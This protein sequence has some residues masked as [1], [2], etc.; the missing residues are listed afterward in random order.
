[1]LQEKINLKKWTNKDSH[2]FLQSTMGKKLINR[3]MKDGR[4]D[5]AE[6]I[7]CDVL[8]LLSETLA[9]NPIRV[10]KVA[11]KNVEPL[12]EVKTIRLRGAHYSVPVP[13]SKKRRSSLSM[14]W[15]IET[16]RKKKKGPIKKMLAEEIL[17]A[18]K[19]QGESLKKKI[20]VHKLASANRAY[21]H[22]RWF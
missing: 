12:V 17:L 18:Y 8:L 4:K 21:A 13:L 3:I 1:M 9:Q 10:L 20:S 5:K 19:Q 6:K 7:L 11:I 22:F 14:K 16:S 2:D 15:I